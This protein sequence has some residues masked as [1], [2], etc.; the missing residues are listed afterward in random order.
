MKFCKNLF[1][2]INFEPDSIQPCCN[3]HGIEVPK[4]PFSGGEFPAQAYGA[5]IKNVMARIQ[6]SENVCKGCPQLQTIDKA[7]VETALTF[8]TVSFNQHRF[9]CNCKCEYCNLW[10]HKSRGYGYE[11]LPTLESLQAQNMLDK[12]CFFSWGGG[13]PSILPGFEDAAQWITKHG[14]WQNVHTNALIHS[15]AIGRM[16]RRGQGEIN[17]SLDSSSPEIYKSVKGV[18]GFAKVVDS[19][20]KYVADARSPE[21]IVLKYIIYEKNNQ[22]PEIAQFIKLCAS[23]GIKRIQLSFDFREV[24]AGKVSEQT[25]IAAAFMIRQAHNFGL[26]ATT[27]YLSGEAIEKI[28]NLLITNFS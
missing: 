5:H 25:Y 4:F 11:V 8:K 28:N 13:E 21:Q 3:V 18:N 2:D 17:I 24:N 14:Y 23:L 20:K 27:F 26:E 22:I 6:N 12:N 7:H 9:F 16:L 10:P 15:P 19:L 1:H